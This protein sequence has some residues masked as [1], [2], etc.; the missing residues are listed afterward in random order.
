M[1]IN[2]PPQ[3]PEPVPQAEIPGST[4]DL[5]QVRLSMALLGRIFGAGSNAATNIAGFV[6]VVFVV[7]SVVVLF[8]EAKVA[9]LEVLKALLPMVTLALGYLF[10]S[11]RD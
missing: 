4:I 8:V 2:P 5:Q 3:Q 1:A 9:P 7:V 11:K 6:V 10:G